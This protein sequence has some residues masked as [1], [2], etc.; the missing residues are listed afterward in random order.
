MTWVKRHLDDR[1][2][3][4][5][6]VLSGACP[7][8]ECPYLAGEAHAHHLPG[9]AASGITTTSLRTLGL[10]PR[11]GPLAAPGRVERDPEYPGPVDPS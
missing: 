9:E 8:S 1:G 6:V 11:L 7:W 10:R 5:A 2:R 4:W 3:L